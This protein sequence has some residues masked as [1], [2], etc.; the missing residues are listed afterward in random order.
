[1]FFMRG[2]IVFIILNLFIM[3]ADDAELYND[4]RKLILKQQWADA[5]EK[6]TILSEAH[7]KSRYLDDAYFW[8]AYC[9]EKIPGRQKQAFMAY[10]KI[11]NRFPG[12]SWSDDAAVHQIG[13]AE[14]FVWNG[15][16]QYRS[17]LLEKLNSDNR[18]IQAMSAISLGK[19]G[20]KASLPVL[21]QLMD[22]EE[23]GEIAQ[24]LVKV[25][26]KSI[27]I[28]ASDHVSDDNDNQ[29][30]E[31]QFLYGQP[32]E[33]VEE[34]KKDKIKFLFG[35][36]KRYDHYSSMLHKDDEWSR[37]ELVDFGLWHILPTDVFDSYH[38]LTDS[39]DKKEWLRKY[40]KAMDPTPT[41]EKNEFL[42]EF[43]RRLTFARAH[44]SAFWDAFE[45]KVLPDQYLKLE[46]AHAPWDARG[47]LYIK[48]GEPSSRTNE[49][50]HTE[51][52]V[53]F[54]HNVDFIVRQYMTNIYWNAIEL[55]PMIMQR[56]FIESDRYTYIMTNKFFYH[57]DHNA[58]QL[59][60]FR[61]GFDFEND[62]VFVTYNIPLKQFKSEGE[63]DSYSVKYLESCV[64]F[65]EDYHEVY[66]KQ[67]IKKGQFKSSKGNIFQKMGLT[68]SPGEYILALRVE[69]LNSKKLGIYRKKFEVN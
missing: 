39:Y 55:G 37:E 11:N 2:F 54:N 66:R 36:T 34:T 16:N 52:W 45:F 64:V 61:L 63:D 17:F 10:E 26:E 15:D 31:L 5:I 62:S 58:E 20:E 30:N 7:N 60:K 40:W 22:H 50:W 25:L 49:G 18:D 28:A 69:D 24:T 44:F 56:G 38:S 14:Q 8:I 21:K 42:L 41:T 43:E 1:M 68:L 23:Y 59:D 53:Y 13:L 33:K 12:S 35:T 27:Q 3:A 65:D 9:L 32:Q 48:Y 6:F 47:E 4:G 67:K 19:L 51:E 46:W 29:Q 57:Y